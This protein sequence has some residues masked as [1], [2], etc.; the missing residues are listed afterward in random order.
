M[1]P[2]SVFISETEKP[3]PKPT[4]NSDDS[5]VKYEDPKPKKGP[6]RPFKPKRAWLTEAAQAKLE[7]RLELEQTRDLKIEPHTKAKLAEPL[8]EICKM[9]DLLPRKPLRDE[10]LNDY[11]ERY[12]IKMRMKK[13]W[14]DLNPLLPSAPKNYW[15]FSIFTGDY[16]LSTSLQDR[17]S[18]PVKAPP[19]GL[20]PKLQ[21]LFVTQVRFFYCY[22]RF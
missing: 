5:K 20:H 19:I 2:Y 18:F 12:H 6:K 13:Q 14:S 8:Q 11:D 7:E 3:S 15:N 9:K 21:S 10:N 17:L 16:H 4:L 1:E 22:N